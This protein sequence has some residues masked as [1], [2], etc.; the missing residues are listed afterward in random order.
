MRRFKKSIAI[1]LSVLMLFS[2]SMVG[3]S[4]EGEH[5]YVV[6]GTIAG[7][8]WSNTLDAENTM[9]LGDNS[10]YTKTFTDVP[11]GKYQFKVRDTS[12]ASDEAPGAWFGDANGDNIDITVSQ[13]C[14]VTVTFNATTGEVGFYGDYVEAT[15]GLTVTKMQLM[16]FAGWN[17]STAPE[18]T[19]TTAGVYTYTAENVK[20]G[21]YNYKFAANGDWDANWGA[22]AD[23]EALSGD[24]VWNSQ[25]NFFLS[26]SEVSDVTFTIDISK[27]EFATKS[28]A[29]YEVTVTPA[30]GGET[31][32]TTATTATETQGEEEEEGAYYII[33]S[34][35]DWTTDNAYKLTKNEAAEGNEY[36]YGGLDLTTESQFKVVYEKGNQ[37]TWFPDGMGNNY[38]ENGEITADGSY[39]VY[40]RPDGNGGADWFYNCIYVSLPDEPTEPSESTDASETTDDT[41]ATEPME[42]RTVYFTNTIGWDNVYVYAFK[43][44][45]EE[46][47]TVGEE[48]PG[49][50]MVSNGLNELDQPT[51]MAEIGVD[52]TYV[53]FNNGEGVQSGNL[54][55]ND[56]IDGYWYNSEDEIFVPF[57]FET[58]T[59][60]TEVTEDTTP[61]EGAPT[62][63]VVGSFTDWEIDEA[64][65][66]T[67]NP[68]AE[69]E[70]MLTGVAL[71]A[72]DE[73]KVKSFTAS[74]EGGD[75]KWYPDG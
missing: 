61:I 27:F 19:E 6:R 38:G 66:L 45:E 64:Y 24:A 34:M 10:L 46:G 59:E 55:I 23:D 62:Y 42:T 44:T 56:S 2:V 54:E 35:T 31:T 36:Y 52:A 71:S 9:T 47:V 16:G 11:V 67:A 37:R 5:T 30:E 3:A 39:D 48:W 20:K 13:A 43:G 49:T 65:T 75:P 57:A 51:F 73:F 22:G 25:N 12:I 32:A 74:I 29:V 28:G 50:Q 17:F 14:D 8:D 33:G 26:L 7:A 1:L 69:N 53:V 63:Y 70:Y 68:E 4:A 15:S 72:G 40:F 21:D 58:P 18:M 41:E 60:G